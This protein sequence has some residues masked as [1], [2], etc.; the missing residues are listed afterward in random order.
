MWHRFSIGIWRTCSISFFVT[1]KQLI[2]TNLGAGSRSFKEN[3]FMPQRIQDKKQSS[4]TSRDASAFPDHELWYLVYSQSPPAQKF[5]VTQYQLQHVKL[6]GVF[7]SPQ[8][9]QP[10]EKK[11]SCSGYGKSLTQIKFSIF[12][13]YI[14]T[15]CQNFK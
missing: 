10:L 8:R 13:L 14:M 11:S 5:L 4:W 2:L 3:H 6:C 7:L 15:N 9:K 1:S 12:L